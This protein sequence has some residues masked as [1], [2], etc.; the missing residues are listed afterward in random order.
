MLTPMTPA[1]RVGM[2]QRHRP[3][4]DAAP[5]VADEDGLLD[6]QRVEQADEI[7]GQMMDVVGLDRLAGDR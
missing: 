3:G 5:V 4:D 6:L 1:T 7:A 2:K